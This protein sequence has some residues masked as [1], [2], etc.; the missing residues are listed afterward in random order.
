MAE[1]IKHDAVKELEGEQYISLTTYRRNGN[2]VPTPVWFAEKNGKFYITTN[3]DAGKVKRIRNNGHVKFSACDARGLI[4]GEELTGMASVH[5]TDSEM[6]KLANNALNEKYGMMKRVFDF[7]GWIRQ[8][9]RINVE[10][11]PN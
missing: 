8:S 3:V 4:H 7:L 11:I 1:T 6:G 5:N 9:K 2:A 10:V